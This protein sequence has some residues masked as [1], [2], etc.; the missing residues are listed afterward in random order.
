MGALIRAKDWSTTPLG[1]PSEWPQS[2]CTMVGVMLDNPFGM[3]IAWGSEYTQL[4]NDGYRPIL[5]TNKHPQALGI[6]TRETFSEIWHIIESM[7][8]GVMN[9]KP[10]GYPDLM[11]PLNRNGFVEECYF[12]F[13]YS[14]I[15]KDNGEVG[16]VLVTVVETTEKKR[17]S[18]AL[19]ESNARYINNIMQA[20]VAMCIFRGKNHVVEIANER[21]LQLWGKE[22]AD[23]INKPI[24]EGLPES[25][26]QGLEE[27]ID[28]VYATGEKFEANERPVYLPRKGKVETTYLNFVYDALKDHDGTISGIVAIAVEVTQQVTARIK[29]EESEQKVRAIVEK[30]PF[31]IAVYEGSEMIVEMANQ[32]IIDL[33][34]KGNDVI[35]KSLKKVLPELDNQRVFEQ[36]KHVLATGES[37]DTKNTPLDLVI[38]GLSTTYYFNY[39]FTPLYDTTG[40]VYAVMSSGVDVTDLNK[41]KTIIEQSDKRF[42]NTMKQAPVAITIL[43]G[44]QY[45]VEMANDSFL[46]LIDKREDEFVGNPLFTSLPEI[47]EA[48]HSLLDNVIQT[49]VPFQGNSVQ[50]TVDRYGTRETGYFDFLYHPLKEED[51]KISGVI[52]TVTEV[53]EKVEARKTIEE[54]K[55]LYEAITQ[56]TP[57]L[58]YVFDLNYRFSYA[59]EALLKMWGRS[60]D[61][62]IGKSMLEVG[63]E[64]WHA[65]MHVQEIDQVI[66]TKK[67]I[68]G[69]VSFPHAVLGERIYDYI[70]VPVIDQNGEV[71]A[72]AGTTRDIT[73][74]VENRKLIEDSERRFRHMV[75]QA[76]VAIC[77]LK[78]ENFMIE[79]AN[80]KQLQLWNKTKEQ[81]I[82]KPLFAALPEAD[83]QGF[84]EI[85]YGVFTT[86]K[87]FI[88]NSF[89]VS[90]IRDGKTETSY[91]N[92]VYKP[93]YADNTVVG[94]I[95]VATDVTDQVIARKTIEESEQRF[96]A[97]IAAVEGILWTNN[98]EGCMEGQQTGW[99]SL[100]GQSFEDYVGYG[101]LNAVHPE[102]SQPTIDAWN[103]SVKQRKA[104]IFEHR[105]KTKEGQWRDFSV[106]AIPLIK[107]D[108]TLQ[109]WV[110]VHTDITENKQAAK[111]LKANEEKLTIVIE[112]S[113]LGTWEMDVKTNLMTASERF[114]EIMGYQELQN[115]LTLN[116]TL[117]SVHPDHVQL[118]IQ[119]LKKAYDTGVFHF[120]GPIIWEDH[121][122]HW[123]ESKGKVFYDDQNNPATV[124][125][126]TADITED[127]EQQQI[128]LESEQKFRLLADSMP[129][130]IW[131]SDTEGNLNYYNQSVFDYSGLTFDQI[132]KD[133]WIQI[134]HPND[135][136]EN[137]EQWTKAVSSGTEFLLEH[138]FRR[139][140]GEYRWQLSRAIPQRDGSG[141]IQMWVGTSTDI[142]EQKMREEKK[143]EF[144][145]IAS[146][147][148]KTPLTTAKAYLQMLELSLDENNE[149]LAL[150]TK[151]ANQ[152]VNRLNELIGELLDVSKI[153]LGKLNYTITTFDFNEMIESAVENIQLT[154]QVHKIIKTGKVR[155]AVTGDKER[156]QQVVI[157][158]LTNAIKYSPDSKEV[159]LEVGQKNNIINV[160][161]KDTGIGI[162][163][164]SLEKVFDKYHRIEEHALHFQ[165]LGIGLFI[166]FEIIQ[167]HNGKLWAES[168]PGKGSTFYFSLPVNASPTTPQK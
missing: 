88:A 164:Q 110:G 115:N 90:F 108:G 60:W 137:I 116:D 99:S 162:A 16:G 100:T 133:G 157:N 131:T 24:F 13:S 71:E 47:K 109:Q 80:D 122:I 57:D 149:E 129:Q 7:F 10:I 103:L 51:G 40:N 156:L 15:R 102:D 38:D 37:F 70:F 119:A 27:L 53:T 29:V 139:H 22:A 23:V 64:P 34:G 58:I 52:A 147:E 94:V 152:S 86:G 48:V 41:A 168:E 97:A 117:K 154:S 2:L 55:R 107:S 125:G 25:K 17:I 63:Y 6:S 33:W 30:A 72:I 138:R 123:I 128:L 118:K 5:G 98:A 12:D 111:A 21:M 66:T 84:G 65:Q 83:E 113:E 36:I 26:D 78:G 112:A 91:L 67:S 39:S 14:P 20:P 76:P 95:S 153:R 142:Q 31:P 151:K 61:D 89:P 59:N 35:G 134:V 160:S 121:S 143:D 159:Y 46:Q 85:V 82:D 81:V 140:D 4:Y 43:R 62:S 45:V 56:N 166:S 165:G 155:D 1:D 105:I 87:P 136:K 9:G 11:L 93:L 126:T 132:N 144:I 150:Y 96:Q 130:Q 124:I 167:R 120:T 54:R 3:Y 42:R 163:K 141:K 77:I 73:P 161:V 92:F 158:L 114:Y 101:W 148:M 127:Q 32:T 18:K 79:V 68:R 74:Q 28:R 106:R 49:G 145:S 75:Q 69:E 50:I 104:F 8:D 19:N 44:P 135:R 146:H